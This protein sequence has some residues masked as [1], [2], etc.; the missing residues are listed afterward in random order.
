MLGE[1]EI[2]ELVE[3]VVNSAAAWD[4]PVIKGEKTT[5][6]EVNQQEWEQSLAMLD[7]AIL[8]LIG[9][10]EADASEIADKLDEILGS[11]LWARRLARLQKENQD[12]Y[13]AAI[14]SRARLIWRHTTAPQRKGYYLAGVGWSTGAKLDAV[15]DTANELLVQ[16]NGAIIAG[17]PE[18]AIQRMTALAEIAFGIEPFIPNPFP[19]N[20][21]DVLQAWLSGDPITSI[22]SDDATSVLR[23]IEDALVYRLPWAIEAMRVRALANADKIGDLSLEDF[24]TSSAVPVLETGTL[25]L[26]AAILMQAGF[27]SRLAAIKAVEDTQAE[28]SNSREL[29][30]WL[31][32]DIVQALTH[33]G[34]WP[35]PETAAL[36]RAFLD[37]TASEKNAEWVHETF[38][39]SVQWR[40]DVEPPVPGSF[41]GLRREEEGQTVVIDPCFDSIG[42]LDEALPA[43][44]ALIFGRISEDDPDILKVTFFGPRNAP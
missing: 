34:N 31:R 11:S 8:S 23:F 1:P 25:N 20:W 29:A 3:Y 28:F 32:S 40:D 24:E 12:A 30:A 18:T 42:Y 15:A 13:S 39:R 5:E 37:Q 6:R 35:T 7:T 16:V 44:D 26:P 10:E 9:D 2:S 17:E 43:M 19:D 38:E 36:W 41:V 33:A 21:R 27:A 22:E 4:F 14:K